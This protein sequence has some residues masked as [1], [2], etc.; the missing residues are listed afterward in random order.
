[1][2]E[3]RVN[4]K[5]ADRVAS[6]HPWIFSSDITDRDGAQ[7]GDA[8][9]VADPRG[10]AARHGA[11]QLQLRRSRCACFRAQVGRDRP[12]FLFAPAAR[13]RSA[14]PP[15]GARYRCL[16]RGPRRSRPAAGA[17]CR[18]LRRLPGGADAR[19][20][21][22]RAPRAKSSPAWRRFSSPRAL[23]R[24]TMSPVRRKEQLPLETG[25]RGR[26]GA[27][28]R[29]DAHERAHAGAPI[30]CTGRRPASFSTSARTTWPRR[31]TPAAAARSIASPPPA[32]SPCTWRRGANPWKRWTARRPALAA[33]RANAAANGIGNIE[34]TRSRRVRTALRVLFGAAAVLAGGAGPAGVR[35][36]AAERGGGRARATRRSTC[37]PCACWA[38][39]GFW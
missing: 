6:G 38:R 33:A 24:A 32:G 5:A 35:Q 21:H 28:N 3:V 27:G 8:V 26:R 9:K 19:P 23:W 18:P 37:A 15:G 20:G 11:L 13:G 12:R 1:M 34:F 29:G 14:P 39:A 30:C 10:R 31:A 4:R 17:D 16:P 25:R 36:I 22:G 7:P 2:N